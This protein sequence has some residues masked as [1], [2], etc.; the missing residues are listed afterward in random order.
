MLQQQESE[1]VVILIAYASK[2]GTAKEVAEQLAS[3]IST[4]SS[5][6]PAQVK[7][8]DLTREVPEIGDFDAIIVGSG[9]RIG[10]LHKAAREFLEKNSSELSSKKL[11]IYITHCFADTVEQILGSSVPRKLLASAVWAGSVGGRMDLDNLR[12]LDKVIAKA[13]TKAVKQGERIY[14]GLDETALDELAACFE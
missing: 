6:D 2:S 4:A 12:G 3:L 14:E 7:L 13:A 10:S 9:V 11:G 1:G 8:A 5:V